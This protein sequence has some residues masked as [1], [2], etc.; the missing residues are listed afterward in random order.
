MLES[1]ATN[2]PTVQKYVAVLWPSFL[3]AGVA[4]IVLFTIFDPLEALAC[5]GGPELS[6]LG[7]YSIGFFAFWLLTASA[8]LLAMY[9]EKPCPH[10]KRP[11]SA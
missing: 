11:D 5:T 2:I 7:A 3:T 6:R 1:S 10:V 4:T 9:F 8:C